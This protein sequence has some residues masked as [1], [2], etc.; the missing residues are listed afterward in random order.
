MDKIIHHL[1]E[2]LP[3]GDGLFNLLIF[4]LMV[5]GSL[6]VIFKIL[7]Y[8]GDNA[9]KRKEEK[10]KKK[11]KKEKEKAEK[12]SKEPVTVLH[13]EP[14]IVYKSADKGDEL[15]FLEE[16]K[17]VVKSEPKY[18]N[19]HNDSYVFGRSVGQSYSY[20]DNFI[21][22]YYN[23]GKTVEYTEA[24]ADKSVSKPSTPDI[25]Q[26]EKSERIIEAYNDMPTQLKKYILDKIL[27]NSIK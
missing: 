20:G 1:I 8:I 22:D 11:E 18:S 25:G 13:R 15:E 9:G 16:E 26:K 10:A 4:L 19:E 6:Y 3:N 5:F 21:Y 24:E 23:N 7:F 12:K 2:V 17:V 27:S 14:I